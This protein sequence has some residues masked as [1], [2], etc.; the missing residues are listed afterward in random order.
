VVVLMASEVL[1]YR[2]EGEQLELVDTFPVRPGT[3][4]SIQLLRLGERIGV[5]VNRQSEA[6]R[7]DSLVL[8]V[9]N[10]RLALWQEHLDDILLAVDTDGDG[11][12]DSVWGQPFDTRRFFRE[13]IA[14]QYLLTDGRLHPQDRVTL[15]Y[16][17]RATG[18]ALAQLRREGQRHLVWVDANQRLRVYRGKEELWKSPE[19][20]GGSNVYGETRETISRDEMVSYF[21]F[22]PVPAVM[23][24]NGDGIEEVLVARNTGKVSFVP[25]ITSFSS[26]D[27]MLLR[28][29]KYGYTLSSISPQFNGV[30]S[31]IVA[32]PGNPPAI[33]IA[34][35][36]Y[37]SFPSRS[38]ESWLYLSR[39]PVS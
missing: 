25:N 23:D 13:G 21:Y 35:T 36:K 22:E 39:V 37:K 1:L 11:V 20:V 32:L 8:I 3:L 4:L 12:N 38:G 15:P 14:Q 27:V 31:G 18:A 28:E 34:V 19:N 16:N 2:L 24:V 5:V 29:E 6:A 33:L 30:V 17:F 26:G 9:Q 10:Q 7:M